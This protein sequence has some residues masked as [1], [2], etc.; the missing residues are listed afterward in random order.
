M[1]A[2]AITLGRDLLAVPCAL[3]LILI[4]LIADGSAFYVSV[5][6][7]AVVYA[8]ATLGQGILIGKTGQVSL[9]GAALMA[10]GAY[11]AALITRIDA[12][13]AFPVPLL[14]AALV[15]AAVG[16]VVALPGLRF[17]G[18]YLLLATLALQYVVVFAAGRLEQRP[19][20]LAG[21]VVENGPGSS[22]LGYGRPFVET[23]LAVLILVYVAVKLAYRGQPGRVLAAIGESEVAAAAMGIDVRRWKVA[24]FIV[25]SAVTAVAGALF[26]YYIGVITSASFDLTLAITIL[27]MTFVGGAGTAG[28]PIVGAVVVTIFPYLTNNLANRVGTDTWLGT[29]MPYLQ[30]VVYGLALT[31]VLLYARSGLAGID[32][33]AAVRRLRSMRAPGASPPRRAARTS[34]A[35][36]EVS[37]LSVRYRGDVVGIAGANLTV[38]AGEIVAIVG[39]NG[40]GKTSLLRGIVG[41]AR[42]GDFRVEGTV[43]F[44]GHARRRSRMPDGLVYVAE[45]LKV[46]P[47]LTVLEHFALVGADRAA[48]MESLERANL[49]PLKSRLDSPAGLLSGGERQFVALIGALLRAP[50]L[51]LLDEMSLGLA[52][53]AVAQVIEAIARIREL[54]GTGVVVVDQNVAMLSRIAD[55]IVV[56]ENGRVASD[57]RADDADVEQIESACLGVSHLVA[58]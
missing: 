55:R 7:A 56:V 25:S 6:G 38:A 39:R 2:S 47:G 52:P 32:A 58:R 1:R 48:V 54:T 19:Q 10:V 43:W 45:Q 42:R 35:L 12:F 27:I 23:S 26:A 28:G 20:F 40:A 21:V 33:S 46:F 11:S 37:E 5:A 16:A 18:L 31:L 13:A 24:A 41:P 3:V 29:N 14:F 44:D 15:G 57:V 8:I 22:L 4:A 50:K 9:G 17:R 53:I 34:S 36:L 51:L 30:V 49:T